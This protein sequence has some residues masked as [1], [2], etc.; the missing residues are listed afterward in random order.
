M[1]LIMANNNTQFGIAY[2]YCIVYVLC[3]NLM[4]STHTHISNSHN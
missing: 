3:S 1:Y 4:C 2:V